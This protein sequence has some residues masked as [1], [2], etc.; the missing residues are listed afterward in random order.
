MQ[1][2]KHTYVCF[3]VCFMLLNTSHDNN[4]ILGNRYI[5]AQVSQDTKTYLEH[6]NGQWSIQVINAIY[7]PNSNCWTDEHCVL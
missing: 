1:S 5:C 4:D 6:W 3:P 2:S 7:L